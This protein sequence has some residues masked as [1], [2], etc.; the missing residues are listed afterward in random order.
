MGQLAPRFGDIICTSPMRGDSC[1]AIVRDGRW[2]MRHAPANML[3]IL[4]GMLTA[5]VGLSY[6]RLL[7]LEQG[8]AQCV[9]ATIVLNV[10]LSGTTSISEPSYQCCDKLRIFC[11]VNTFPKN[12]ESKALHVHH[13]WARRCTDY[14]FTSTQDHSHLPILKLNLTQ[15]ET[16]SHLWSKMRTILREVYK[17][18]DHYDYF[19]KADDDTY[20]VYENLQKILE[21]RSPT[22]PFMT[23]YLWRTLV[24]GGYFSGGSGYVLSREA[25]KRIVEE[26]ID[27]HPKCPVVDEDK[28]DVKMSAC[29][30][31]VGVK[32]HET[33]GPD[34]RS[35]FYPYDVGDY[36]E[37]VLTDRKTPM[38][39]HHVSF[40]YVNASKM[41][42]M[43]FSLYHLRPVGLR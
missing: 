17:H 22:Q 33:I 16:R 24:K 20:A 26:A 19:Y 21:F 37:D 12:Y 13:T 15:P 36:A 34:G 40:H 3:Y 1:P 11:Y 43:E 14:V 6:V 4:L 32:L 5:H 7:I 10:N 29:G 25:L 41:Y 31:A 35:V 23:G 38:N 28:E 8:V 27:K 42:I 39:P 2:C 9:P 30:Q 18:A